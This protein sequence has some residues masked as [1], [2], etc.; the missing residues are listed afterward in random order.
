MKNNK[1]HILFLLSIGF[2]IS[3]NSCTS[4]KKLL[5]HQN[6]SEIQLPQKIGDY[7]PIYSIDDALMILVTSDNPEAA[8]P[9]NL[10]VFSTN[11]NSTDL[12]SLQKRQL[13]YIV[14]KDGTITYPVLGKIKVAGL[15]KS[16]LVS[17]LEEKL[18]KYISNPIISV[19]LTN[20]EVS[21]LGDVN[22]P[23]TIKFETDK[24][25]LIE[26][27]T[28]AGDLTITG[29]RRNI[30]I[31]REIDGAIVTGT[32]DLTDA[33]F[34]NSPYYYIKPN[35]YIYVEPNR[36]KTST[37]ALSP[38]VSYGSIFLSTAITLYLLTKNN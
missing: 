4:R 29:E 26:C 11:D 3:L 31:I 25:T 28:K 8:A 2:L 14:D 36:I 19:R 16:E 35:D 27:L 37:T 17:V 20:F 22:R 15:K 30:R 12:V 5:Y 10:L 9:F 13:N 1:L 21:V 6:I 32:V 7:E 33:N 18:K 38:I 24:V 34:F 23:G